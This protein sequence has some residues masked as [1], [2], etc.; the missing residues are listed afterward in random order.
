MIEA[1]LDCQPL[2]IKD[3]LEVLV[4]YALKKPQ[5][6]GV[7]HYKRRVLRRRR[8]A[9]DDKRSRTRLF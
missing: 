2:R 7:Q 3:I 6:D 8:H 1:D 4:A 5:I 9:I